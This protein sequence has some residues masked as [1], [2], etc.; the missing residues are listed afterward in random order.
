MPRILSADPLPPRRCRPMGSRGTC[1]CVSVGT[2]VC[3]ERPVVQ[4]ASTQERT[5][6]VD[7]HRFASSVG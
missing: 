2:R 4:T 3:V 7:T 1:L 5:I 6:S